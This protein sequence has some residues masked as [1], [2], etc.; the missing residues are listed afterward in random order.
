MMFSQPQKQPRKMIGS[1]MGG[2]KAILFCPSAMP[3]SKLYV[4][5]PVMLSQ[6]LVIPL[7]VS[8][9]PLATASIRKPIQG[10]LRRRLI[11][12]IT[13]ATAASPDSNPPL[14]AD[15]AALSAT[16][17]ENQ[18]SH[19]TSSTNTN[20]GSSIKPGQVPQTKRNKVIA[21]AA[22]VVIFGVCN[23]VLYKVATTS[24]ENYIFFLAQLQ[25]FGYILVYF[26]FLAFR[27]K[28]GAA[29]TTMLQIPRLFW[30]TFIAIGVVE[31]LS[32]VLS[33]MGAAK[34]PGIILPLLSQSIMIWQVLLAYMVGR[35]LSWAQLLG[36]AMVVGG[37]CLA[38][39]PSDPSTSPLRGIDPMY[40]G[41]FVFSMLFPALDTILKERVFR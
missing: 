3:A 2:T 1:S 39:W 16:E 31:A 36:V 13:V 40:A 15:S 35:R 24:M 27:F 37:V 26:G 29:T 4:Q 9:E 8:L 33:F 30:P 25:T 41:I 22:M 23:R 38:G 19:A 34:L 12:S 17:Q 32:S 20:T 21:T 28:S 5:P 18:P 10:P 14:S 11:S 7:F 6:T